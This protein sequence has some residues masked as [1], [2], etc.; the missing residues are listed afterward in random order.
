MYLIFFEL[1]Y[2][3]AQEKND[4]TYFIC[5]FFGAMKSSATPSTSSSSVAGA[6]SLQQQHA[7]QQQQP[8][9]ISFPEL[10]NHSITSPFVYVFSHA[11]SGGLA[12]FALSFYIQPSTTEAPLRLYH[13]YLK[14]TKNNNAESNCTSKFQ[15][16]QTS[17]TTYV[18]IVNRINKKKVKHE[19]CLPVSY[20]SRTRSWFTEEASF[21]TVSQIFHFT[22]SDCGALA[23]LACTSVQIEW[24]LDH[25]TTTSSSSWVPMMQIE[26]RGPRDVVLNTSRPCEEEEE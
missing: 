23:A 4:L 17:L 12:K 16:V 15:L 7:F 5:V 18:L 6:A 24:S 10:L 11:L 14:T 1:D 2:F 3:L 8:P 22:A 26:L 20:R 25:G 19:L 21:H 9:I 13:G